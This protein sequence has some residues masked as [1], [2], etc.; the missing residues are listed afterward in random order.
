[1]QAPPNDDHYPEWR[2]RATRRYAIDAPTEGFRLRLCDL[3]LVPYAERPF[4]FCLDGYPEIRGTTDKEGFAIV[5]TPPA[6]AQGYVEMW[7]DDAE[8]DDK[9]RWD[10]SIASIISPA[11]PRGASTRLFNLD[12]SSD[13][14]TDEM[15]DEL[16]EAVRYF[17]SDCD[18]LEVTGE[19]DKPT[20]ERL[21]A[22]HDCE[23]GEEGGDAADGAGDASSG[24]EG[25]ST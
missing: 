2:S 5:D 15:T 25:A 20:C 21:V 7:P 23:G 13:D 24:T 6:D 10:I 14:P 11:T 16:R 18:G 22:I 9:V 17:Q 4:S 19:L 1:V 8:P 12:F 3:D